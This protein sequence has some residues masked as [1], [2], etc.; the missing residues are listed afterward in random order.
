ME[1]AGV[2]EWQTRGTQ[3][4]LRD[5]SCLYEKFTSV[6]WILKVCRSRI[7]YIPPEHPSNLQKPVR[8]SQN[9]ISADVAEWQT[10]TTQ[11]PLR[12]FPYLHKKFTRARWILRVCRN[13]ISYIPPEHPS[14]LQK[15]VLMSQNWISADVA[16]WQTQTTQNRSGNHVGSSP[17]IGTSS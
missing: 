17:T 6:R 3:N 13:G 7:S 10:Q 8:M 1:S 2:S 15:P 12:D 11:N 14:N 16:E 4:P 9:W 5:F